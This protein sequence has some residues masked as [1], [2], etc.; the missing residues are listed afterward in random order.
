MTHTTL[1]I[2][3]DR[4]GT[5]DLT[6]SETH[7]LLSSERR[8]AVLDVLATRT[9]PVDLSDI[10]RT[11]AARENADEPDAKAIERVAVSLHHV[12]LPLIAEV[13]VIDYDGDANRVVSS[14]RRPRS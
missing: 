1:E 5:V 12:H 3:E 4:S 7:R 6:E 13:G 10:A 8:R 9:D 14:P 2:P 11:V